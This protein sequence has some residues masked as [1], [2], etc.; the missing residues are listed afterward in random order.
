MAREVRRQQDLSRLPRPARRSRDRRGVDRHHVGPAHRAGDRG[1]RRPASM[2]SSKSRS[3]VDGRRLRRRS[4][5]RR[6]RRK[7]ILL[8]GHICRFNPR[9]R[10][11]KQAI[12]DGRDRQDRVAHLAPQH[13][14]RLDADHPQQ[15]RPDRRRR[16]PR[17][18]PHAVV[19]RR[20]RRQRLC[21]DRRCARPQASRHRPDH[22]PLRRRR[23]RDARDG[24]VHAGEDAI[25]HRRAHVR[26]SAPR[27]SSTSRT[28]SRTSASSTADKFHSPDTTYW[29]MF[30]GVRGGALREEFAYFANCALAGEEPQSAARRTRWRRSRRRSPPRNP[31]GR[32]GRAARPLAARPA[33]APE[34]ELVDEI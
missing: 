34:P 33:S 9:Y 23:H 18:R 19:H 26:S 6:Q 20:P 12:D 24:L 17:H 27:A 28:R 22:V 5:P 30:D 10:M 25:R 32:A 1:A 16:H 8:I 3:P 29:P 11:A 7:G 31:R 21:A 4:S 2:S 13:P 15:D 14:R